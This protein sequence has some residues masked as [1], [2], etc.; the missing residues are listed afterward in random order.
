[1]P[2]RRWWA[3]TSSDVQIEEVSVEHSL[4]DA[5]DDS[6][7][8]EELLDVVAVHPVEDVQRAVGAEGEQVVR[9]DSLRLASLGQ[10]EQLWHDRYRLQVNAECPQH[11]NI[12][13]VSLHSNQSVIDIMATSWGVF[14]ILLQ[15]CSVSIDCTMFCI[16]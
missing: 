4:D 13:L 12:P 1:M 3:L 7:G 9:R 10:H 8:I 11:L 16:A 2:I 15:H 6:D 5:G 14:C